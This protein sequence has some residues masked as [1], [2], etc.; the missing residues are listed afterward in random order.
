MIHNYLEGDPQAHV[1]TKS[2]DQCYKTIAQE[3]I[4]IY[5]IEKLL[6]YMYLRDIELLLKF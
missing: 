4:V 2:S 3:G 1:W 5:V 6:V